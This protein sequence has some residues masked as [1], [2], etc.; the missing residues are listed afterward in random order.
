M[1][2]FSGLPQARADGSRLKRM[3]PGDAIDLLARVTTVNVETVRIAEARRSAAV[4]R[5]QAVQ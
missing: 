4:S 3:L 2:K 5:S 1:G